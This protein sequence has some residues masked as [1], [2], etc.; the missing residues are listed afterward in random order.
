MC[1]IKNGMK[2]LENAHRFIDDF[3]KDSDDA[4]LNWGCFMLQ[5]S[6]ELM[7]KGLC[8]TYGEESAFGHM[9]SDNIEILKN[10]ANVFVSYF[11]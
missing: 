2:A 3:K 4:N 8:E 7:L 6:I 11:C 9:F 5:Q 1:K 10:K